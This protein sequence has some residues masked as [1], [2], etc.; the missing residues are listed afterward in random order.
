MEE[1]G[2]LRAWNFQ[3]L[4]C[5]LLQYI[6][7]SIAF[8]R[9]YVA[10]LH[11]WKTNFITVLDGQPHARTEETA[12]LEIVQLLGTTV[13]VVPCLEG[14]QGKMEIGIDFYVDLIAIIHFP[15]KL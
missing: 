3:W 6:G 2:E 13:P 8:G 14:L 4:G 7:L 1:R 12:R 9:I 15:T 10:R 11:V 5:L